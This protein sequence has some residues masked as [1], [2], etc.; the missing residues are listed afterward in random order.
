MVA[1]VPRRGV[2]LNVVGAVIRVL[3]PAYAGVLVG[4][5]L[6]ALAQPLLLA[7]VTRVVEA[8]VPTAE[9]P[10]AIGL[11]SA[12]LFAGMLV[13][14]V[15]G[16]LFGGDR[17]FA[18]LLVQAALTVLASAAMGLALGRPIWSQPAV[19][20]RGVALRSV[21]ARPVIRSLVVVAGLG[22]GVFVAVTTWLQALLAPAGISA[23]L[24]GLML[25]VMVVAGIVA[26]VVLPGPVIRSGRAVTVL[27][28]VVVVTVLACLLLAVAPGPVSGLLA[29]AT[30]GLALLGA[31]PIILSLV[32]TEGGEAESTATGLVWLGGNLG[33]IVVS[34]LVQA[35]LG[36]PSLAFG[37]MAA[38]MLLGLPVLFAAAPPR[39]VHHAPENRDWT[40]LNKR[41][42]E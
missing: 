24:A 21:L 9:R 29:A 25:L 19:G 27:A 20:S 8:S 4:Q 41:V 42:F 15:T 2:A 12:G 22:F 35:A 18:L 10:R 3:S 37:L 26:G 7:A 33:G 13:A 36:R 14:L 38:L 17:L 32:E 31:L 1:A 23:D 16:P 28:A 5:I 34:L 11:A 40:E 39:P 30:F 6:I